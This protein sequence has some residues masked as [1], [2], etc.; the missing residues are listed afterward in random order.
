MA[1]SPREKEARKRYKELLTEE[2]VSKTSNYLGRVQTVL[3]DLARES[4]ILEAESLFAVESQEEKERIRDW[5]VE[6]GKS[7]VHDTATKTYMEKFIAV[8]WGLPL[9]RTRNRVTAQRLRAPL[10]G[11]RLR[12]IFQKM[13]GQRTAVV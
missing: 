6:T 4:G 9:E 10:H 5:W 12:L 13:A 8:F 3:S 7:S 2:G 11:L 1:F